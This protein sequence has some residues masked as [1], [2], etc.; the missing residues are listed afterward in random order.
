ML[1]QF[2]EFALKGNVIDLAVGV[3]IGAAFQSI[4]KSL[5]DDI[6]M[7]AISLIFGDVDFSGLAYTIGDVS[8]RYGAFITAIVNFLLVAF[9]LFLFVTYINKLNAKLEKAKLDQL[10]GLSHLNEKLFKNRKSKKKKEKEKEKEEV[11]AEPT[12]K[13]CPFCL[14]EVHFKASRCPH[15]TSELET[16][17]VEK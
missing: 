3:I 7:P 13:I 14:S 2:K 15:C 4:V 10:A 16:A 1:K 5:V 9:S 6:I 8:I 17:V 12:T 11:V